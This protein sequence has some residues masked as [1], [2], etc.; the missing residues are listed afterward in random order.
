VYLAILNQ[1]GYYVA[2]GR[3]QY[4]LMNMISREGVEA[5]NSRYRLLLS[6]KYIF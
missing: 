2:N 3:G 6:G 4:S 5:A 1:T